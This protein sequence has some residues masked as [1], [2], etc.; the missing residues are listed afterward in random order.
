MERPRAT[1]F[2]GKCSGL[3]DFCHTEF[4]AYYTLENKSNKTYEYQSD[5]LD[6]NLVE[7]DNEGCSYSQQIELIISGETMRYC[8][9]KRIL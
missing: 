6:D 1:F 7:N 4:L 2:S 9:V 8:K 3:N 5:E